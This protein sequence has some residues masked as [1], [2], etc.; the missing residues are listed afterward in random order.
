MAAGKLHELY[1]FDKRSSA[2]DGYGNTEGEWVEQFQQRGGASY[3]RG[4]EKADDAASNTTQKLI[5]KVRASTA[6]KAVTNAW[7]IRDVRS[8]ET[9]N[10][11][12]PEPTLDR[13]YIDFIV[14]SGVADG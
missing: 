8:D 9:Y 7:R 11:I 5:I 14:E 6:A 4:I 2:P 3:F 10:V 13:L 12:A 1:G